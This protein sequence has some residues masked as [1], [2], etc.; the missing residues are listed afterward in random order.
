MKTEVRMMLSMCRA[1]EAIR[2]GE[3]DP[4]QWIFEEVQ[5]SEME[6]G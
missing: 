4:L 1:A 2:Q 3:K 6:E 5:A